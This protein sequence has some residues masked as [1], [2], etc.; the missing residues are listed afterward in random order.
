VNVPLTN[1]TYDLKKISQSVDLIFLMA[2]DEHWSSAE[3]GPIASDDWFIDGVASAINEVPREKLVVTLGNYG[4]DWTIG[5]KNSVA[6]TFQEVH[7]TMRE[8]E[9]NIY[10]DTGSMN[11]MYSY[12]DDGGKEHEVWYLDAITAH[13]ELT[14]L[15]QLGISNTAL[16]RLGSEDPS[17]WDVFSDPKNTKKLQDLSYGYEIDYEGNGELYKLQSDPKVG[18]RDLT[19]SGDLI[20]GE[21]IKIFPLPY[22]IGRYSDIK[23][24]KIALT[25]DDGPD[26][27]VTP[28]ILDILK[29][30]SVKATFFIIGE[31]AQKYPA[32]VQRIY[33]EGHIIGNHSFS[34]PDISKIGT[35]RTD[36]ELTTTERIIESTIGHG[37]ILF[38]PPYAEDIEPEIPSQ[39]H[40]LALSRDLGYVTVGMRID[41]ND[42]ASPGVEKIIDRTLEAADAKKGNIVLLH[43]A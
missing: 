35:I 10:F 30:Y 26:P 21:N 8:S 27:N 36:M 29:K 37:T 31:N 2:Y 33:D 18:Y 38:R 24:K 39:V 40:P 42:W 32:L 3:P 1:D 34:H 43:D 20:S 6:M 41:P 9:E 4:Y 12:V 14:L 5:K 22:T 16:W 11:P 19:L 23:E 25:F 15:D 28:Q 17:I 7:T 13:N